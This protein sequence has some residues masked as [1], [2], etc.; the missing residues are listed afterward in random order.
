MRGRS[1]N[2]KIL[3]VPE[4][5]ELLNMKLDG[6]RHIT[7]FKDTRRTPGRIQIMYD[8][9][10]AMLAKRYLEAFENGE[11]LTQREVAEEF[12]VSTG[13]ISKSLSEIRSNWRE[14]SIRD[15]DELTQ[16]KL[17]E[18]DALKN[19]AWEAWHN[20]KNPSE[21]QKASKD[22]HGD[23]RTEVVIKGQTGDVKYL[24]EINRCIAQEMK[25][26]GLE[27]PQEIEISTWETKLLNYLKD[28]RVQ[29][30]DIEQ[31]L[32]KEKA[33]IFARKAGLISSGRV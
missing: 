23:I 8:A 11:K 1:Y 15:W 5:D 16:K 7:P 26:L 13:R 20:S 17:A 4:I 22:E 29:I 2:S 28:G 33:Q 14:S 18:L 24:A 12:N 25:L 9:Q 10:E 32:G 19:E 27:A 31:Y 30:E 3:H 21:T 6:E